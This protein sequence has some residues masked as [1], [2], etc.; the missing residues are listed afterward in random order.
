M[1][2]VSLGTYS[3][4]LFAFFLTRAWYLG[5]FHSPLGAVYLGSSLTYVVLNGLTLLAATIFAS[6]IRRATVYNIAV[7]SFVVSMLFFVLALV[8]TLDLSPLVFVQISSQPTLI[9]VSCVR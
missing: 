5:E 8:T 9:F 2:L 4:L 6:G 1:S 7:G 3:I